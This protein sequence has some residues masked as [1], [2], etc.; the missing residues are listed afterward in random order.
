M[1]DK[2]IAVKESELTNVAAVAERI[3]LYVATCMKE[4]QATLDR[5]S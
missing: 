2:V 3:G 5:A 4:R 1:L